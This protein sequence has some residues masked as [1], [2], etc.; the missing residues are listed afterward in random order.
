MTGLFITGYNGMPNIDRSSG[1][2]RKTGSSGAARKTGSS[3]AVNVN[4]S[5]KI[6][7][8]GDYFYTTSFINGETLKFE[9]ESIWLETAL[10]QLDAPRVKMTM[11][12]I[13]GG[14]L[15]VKLG[16]QERFSEA[17]ISRFISNKLLDPGIRFYNRITESGLTLHREKPG[18]LMMRTRKRN[19]STRSDF[20]ISSKNNP[21]IITIETKIPQLEKM[22][23]G[24]SGFN[25]DAKFK[26]KVNQ[27]I[28]QALTLGTPFGILSDGVLIFLFEI[29][30][31]TELKDY[32]AK[33][34]NKGSKYKELPI[35][36]KVIRARE[37]G[38]FLIFL[39]FLKKAI[40]FFNIHTREEVKEKLQHF[41]NWLE[42]SVEETIIA[43]TES[44]DK[45]KDYFLFSEESENVDITRD[46]NLRIKFSSFQETDRIQLSKLPDERYHS[47]VLRCSSQ[48][49]YE[50][51]DSNSFNL[52][53][54]REY[55]IKWI[56]PVLAVCNNKRL[57]KLAEP[58]YNYYKDELRIYMVLLEK[59]N[60]ENIVPKLHGISF[61]TLFGD[62]GETVS[63]GLFLLLDYIDGKEPDFSDDKIYEKA[64]SN[65]KKLHDADITH[66]DIRL[67]N[68]RVTEKQYV[69]FFDFGL[70]STTKGY[71]TR[72]TDIQSKRDE[73]KLYQLREEALKAKEYSAPIIEER[74]ETMGEEGRKRRRLNP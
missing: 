41:A 45:M 40:D 39:L 35:N 56:D 15:R 66:G 61:C 3:G 44:R 54:G 57:I 43:E 71:K 60:L 1:A 10:S 68:I 8:M 33:I 47:Q 59:T 55:I 38:V 21:D 29:P 73:E 25:P 67:P 13:L 51:T 16:P 30:L 46:M 7:Q 6:N 19:V 11:C 74:E 18:K 65:L 37:N 24:V 42:K 53:S 12:I 49:F 20:T 52:I 62:N 9:A 31:D 23:G 17:D 36:Y 4:T 70:S 2:A 69:Y 14:I 26:E 27:V 50:A 5:S 34:P 72:I 28:Q 64:M 48:Q 22:V 63:A 58:C 32:E